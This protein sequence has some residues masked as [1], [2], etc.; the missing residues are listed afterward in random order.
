MFKT[1]NVANLHHH[2]LTIE[3]QNPSKETEAFS[4]TLPRWV[5][6]KWCTPTLQIQKKTSMHWE[7]HDR[8]QTNEKMPC[9]LNCKPQNKLKHLYSEILPRWVGLKWCNPTL[10][11]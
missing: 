7:V 4:E 10:Q 5:G 2:A 9:Q 3:L 11:I 8:P 6:L 1:N